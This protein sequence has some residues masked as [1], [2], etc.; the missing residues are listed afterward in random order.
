[1]WPTYDRV[2]A[3]LHSALHCPPGQPEERAGVLGRLTTGI[4]EAGG[5]IFAIENFITKGPVLERTIVVNCS[6][7]E[8][9]T[10]HCRSR[11]R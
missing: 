5:N 8:H 7:V 3:Y 4:G 10:E 1:M 11:A 9:Q 2:R 6:S